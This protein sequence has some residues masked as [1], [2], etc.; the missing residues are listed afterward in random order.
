MA[1]IK[2]YR[3]G[4]NH[5]YWKG[6]RTRC[7]GYIAVYVSPDDF[8][9]P[10]HQGRN[11]RVTEHRLVM[12]KH[13]GRNLQPWEIVHHKN[14]IRDD[15]RIENLQL[16]SADKHTQITQLER[17]IKAFEKQIQRLDGK[18]QYQSS[19]IRLLKWL[20]KSAQDREAARA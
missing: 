17:R 12:A 10:M 13:L 19:Q 18:L 4:E 1:N 15:N 8:F 20:V 5:P 2:H 7:N 16:V 14:G 3:K 11:N 6:G 9:Y